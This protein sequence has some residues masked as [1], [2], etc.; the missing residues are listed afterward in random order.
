MALV[1]IKDFD[2]NYRETF[3]GGDI[4]G[5]SV[6][7][8]TD[9]KVGTVDDILIDENTGEFRYLIVDLGFWIFGKKVLLPVGRSR[10]DQGA[11]RV[12]VIG[13]N[14]EQAENLPEFKS[15]MTVDHDYE[16]SV[17]GVYRPSGTAAGGS[18]TDQAMTGTYAATDPA[19]TGYATD[20]TMTAGV[21]PEQSLDNPT[22][23]TAA[24]G[25]VSDPAITGYTTDPMRTGTTS[26]QSLDNP[27]LTT[28]AAYDRNTYSYD[29]DPDLYQMPEANQGL[30]LYQERLIASKTR[31]KAGE[32]TVGKHVETEV[33]QVSVPIERERVVIE[34]TTPGDI[35]TPVMPGEATFQEGEVARV[36]VYEETPDV[37][38]EAFVR[39]EVQVRKEVD[40]EVVNAEDTVRREEIDIH[41]EGHPDVKGPGTLGSDRI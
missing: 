18:V 32:V 11:D 25:S 15:D 21:M 38:K 41:T 4:K 40:R 39:E 16:E 1:K 29:R 28:A 8:E 23:T 20:P 31:V 35:G 13:L 33:A 30:R 7:T 37:H 26:E 2:P 24:G 12:Y 22:L 36:E 5:A 3:G 10:M 6:Y 14:R 19:M 27:T 9:E 17:R 34:R